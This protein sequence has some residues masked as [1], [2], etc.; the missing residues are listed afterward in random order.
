MPGARILRIVVMK[1]IAPKIDEKP[2]AKRPMMIKSKAG[3]GEPLVESG[4]YM[5]QPPPKPLP[6][7][8]PGTKKLI[9]RQIS[10]V[11]SNQKD[12]SGCDATA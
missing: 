10:A 1:L 12:L 9:K 4:G 3:P 7:A 11:G 6:L 8:E 5:T 2:A